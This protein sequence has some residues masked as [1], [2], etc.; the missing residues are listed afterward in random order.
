MSIDF[1]SQYG[2]EN[3][4][5]RMEE[6]QRYQDF[7]SGVDQG[8][9]RGVPKEARDPERPAALVRAAQR[10]LLESASRFRPDPALIQIMNAA[11][12]LRRPL[13][14]AGEP[15]TGK[16]QVAYFLS[17]Y[18][19]LTLELFSVKSNST[20]VDLKYWFDSVGYLRTANESPEKRLP[21]E[22]FLHEGPLWRSFEN[23]SSSV[24]LIDE[25]DKAHRDF[26]NDL[27]E[28]LDQGAFAH[29]FSTKTS[30]KEVRA[31]DRNG[32][33]TAPLVVIT[34][35]AERRLPDAFLR[36]C[37]FHYIE[38][39][40]EL[41][42]AAMEAHS[43]TRFP[44][45]SSEFKEAALRRFQDLRSKN[46]RLSRAPG[47]GEFLVWLSVLDAAQVPPTALA[48]ELKELPF[49]GTLIKDRQ[50]LVALGALPE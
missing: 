43:R 25:I 3:P 23:P 24:L 9:P 6:R 41:V 26:P 28:E 45:L 35:N 44:G 11:I 2:L 20:A 1:I 7:A 15:G 32:N 50:D 40:V 22:E 17:W 16:T 4:G 39:T 38:L 18:L 48:G 5:F 34:S 46:L 8:I 42:R 36:R 12:L 31:R 27:L 13:L 30:P 29:P 21:R 33:P 14:L 10:D 49:L 37:V 19:G 47:T